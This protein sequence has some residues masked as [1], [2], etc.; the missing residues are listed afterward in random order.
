MAALRAEYKT[1]VYRLLHRSV[2]YHRS[3][4]WQWCRLRCCF[5]LWDRCS[6]LCHSRL[7]DRSGCL[8]ILLSRIAINRISLWL[9]ISR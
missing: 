5:R 8:D 6:S 7:R 4:L 1:A 3:R 2:C 9:I